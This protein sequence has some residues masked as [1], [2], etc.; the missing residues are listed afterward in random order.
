MGDIEFKLFDVGISQTTH[1]EDFIKRKWRSAKSDARKGHQSKVPSYGGLFIRPYI[2]T[3]RDAG[4][5]RRNLDELL[6]T[7]RD[8]LNPD[9]LAWWCPIRNVMAGD[10]KTKNLIVGAILI[11][12]R[13]IK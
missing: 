9:V 11:I 10:S 7:I 13:V 4:L 3:Q 8:S 1:F 12:K 2:G 5:Y 6:T